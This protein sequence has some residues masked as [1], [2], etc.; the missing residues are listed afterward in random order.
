M[1]DG[2]EIPPGKAFTY[3]GVRILFRRRARDADRSYLF[4]DPEGLQVRFTHE[5]LAQAREDDLLRDWV[6]STDDEQEGERT[7]GARV[8]WQTA[9]ELERE[10]ALRHLDYC[11][12]WANQP[13]TP[14]SRKGLPPLIA[15]VHQ[16]RSEEARKSRR[17]EPPAPCVSSVQ[18]WL[19]S[20]LVG[21]RTIESLV[22]QER[23]RGNRHSKLPPSVQELIAQA[24]DTWYLTRDRLPV[25]KVHRELGEEI[26][27]LNRNRPVGT[28][29]STPG[30]DTVQHAISKLCQFTVDFCRRGAAHA[31][32]E[33]RAIGSG[34]VTDHANEVWEIDDTRADLICLSDEGRM[35]IGRPWL[36]VVIDRHTRMIMGFVICFSPPDTRVALEALRMAMLSKEE[37]LA[38]HPSIRGKYEARGRP[39]T[40]HVDNAKHYNSAALTRALQQLGINHRTMPVLKAWY[41]GTVERAIGTLSRQVFHVVPGTTYSGI[42]ERDNDKDRLP[43]LV[44][45][46]TIGELRE[47]LLRWLVEDYQHRHHKGI[48]DT[49]SNMWKMSLA[50]TPQRLPL[51]RGTIE[52]ALS[53][54]D[55]RT[56]RKDG[57]QFRNLMYHSPDVVRIRMLPK[58]KGVNEVTIRVNPDNL[59]L[60]H[61]L[62]PTSGDWLPAYLRR[63]L[64][65]RVRGRTLDEYDLARALRH[66]RPAEF[67]DGDPDY[68]ETYADI[69]RGREKAAGS[70]KLGE[71]VK[72]A[73]ERERLLQRATR[74]TAPESSPDQ[75]AG[76]SLSD[77]V[78][79]AARGDAPAR[80]PQTTLPVTQTA[81]TGAWA[82]SRGLGVRVRRPKQEG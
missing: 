26:K 12:E 55:A 78:D 80:P 61:F 46:A 17:Y 27:R 47:K 32:E 51:E 28:R 50:R 22:P 81:D 15:G 72:A 35:V 62:D 5:E 48:D 79:Q 33:W 8:C 23:K 63:D 14:R 16:R 43:E 19:S 58:A 24:I 60:I 65:V 77:L 54:T 42:Y 45:E 29:I 56:L 10:E 20:W 66:N 21:G 25:A 9:T 69:D 7:S 64:E 74:L 53:L 4:E 71:R 13:G 82:A 18:G 2:F 11:M 6:L 67:A 38:R 73:A 57:L 44:A 3:G 36:V 75:D 68:S 52:A 39:D 1:P 31:R 34:L 30:Y 76:S 37:L 40:V 49:P 70:A 59:L 41:K